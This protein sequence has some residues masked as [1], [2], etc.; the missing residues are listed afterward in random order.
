M[1]LAEF[2]EQKKGD[3]HSAEALFRKVIELATGCGRAQAQIGQ[4]FVGN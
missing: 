4:P 2:Y 3:V 1:A